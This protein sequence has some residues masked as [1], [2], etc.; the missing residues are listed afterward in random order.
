M[1]TLEKEGLMDCLF[2]RQDIRLLN[3]KFFRG[4]SDLIEDDDFREQICLAEKRKAE[5]TVKRADPPKCKKE[6]VDLRNL[7]A[8]M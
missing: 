7:V 3:L 1:S 8:E 5:Q 6:P 4:S 2:S